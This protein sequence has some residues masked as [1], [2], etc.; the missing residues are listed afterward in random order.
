[1]EI[2]IDTKELRDVGENVKVT[3]VMN[4]L[5]IE[6]DLEKTIGASSSGKM[7][8]IGSTGGFVSLPVE[9]SRG[10]KIKMNLYMGDK[11]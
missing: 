7:T 6:I 9:S 10:K 3:Q 5:Y 11:E 4:K 1:M 2:K 8:G